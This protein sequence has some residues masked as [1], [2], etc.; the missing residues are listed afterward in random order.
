MHTGFQVQ[1]HRHAVGYVFI[2]DDIETCAANQ[3]VGTCASH[4]DVIAGTAGNNVVRGIATS[5]EVAGT[6]ESQTLDFTGQGD[7][8][9]C[10]AH[11]VITAAGHFQHVLAG[12]TVDD[13]HVVAGTAVEGRGAQRGGEYVV[14]VRANNGFEIRERVTLRV[15]A[16]T[17]AHTRGGHGDV[18]ALLRLRVA[19]PVVTVVTI[20][21]V[22]SSAGIERI[23][24]I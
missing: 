15:A 17:G 5:I 3:L 9:Q 23:V 18:D 1:G 11:F 12:R 6:G 21:V 14:V 2:A 4:Q 13:V 8:V 20:K 19:Q 10:G 24:I 7:G 22:G 16:Q